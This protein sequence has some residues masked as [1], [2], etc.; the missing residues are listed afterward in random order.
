MR[1]AMDQTLN[2]TFYRQY[3]RNELES[4]IAK[5]QRYSLRAFSKSLGV[6][7]SI[8]SRVLSA[9]MS[10]P[11]KTMEKVLGRL[12]LSSDKQRKFRQSVLQEHQCK[13]GNKYEQTRAKYVDLPIKTVSN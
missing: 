10:M 9:Q 2:K 4:R 5:N 8:L 6:D 12:E 1:R 13:L 7:V 11:F 3:L